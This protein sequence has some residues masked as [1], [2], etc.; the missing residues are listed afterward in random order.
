[1]HDFF[2]QF[3]ITKI[4]VRKMP[5]GAGL[6]CHRAIAAICQM[7][8]IKDIYAKVEGSINVQ[9]LTKAFILGLI[10]QVSNISNCKLDCAIAYTEESKFLITIV[11]IIVVIINI[12]III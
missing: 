12:I 6:I 8:G 7:V 5:E 11:I 2:S 3:G 4:F 1:M 9:N 10:R